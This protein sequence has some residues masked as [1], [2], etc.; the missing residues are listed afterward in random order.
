M[1]TSNISVKFENDSQI[2]LSGNGRAK[3]KLK[4]EWDDDPDNA[5]DAI[6][7]VQWNG[8]N[9]DSPGSDG[10]STSTSN[11]AIRG[12]YNLSYSGQP[13]GKR[14][15]DD[16]TICF[17]D[18]D[19]D[20]CNAYLTIEGSP[21]QQTYTDIAAALT[22]NSTAGDI[23][24]GEGDNVNVVWA[25]TGTSMNN[26]GE[27]SEGDYASAKERIPGGS[28]TEF[29]AKPSGS[30]T[31][32]NL[33]KGT[34]RYRLKTYQYIT[35]TEIEITRQVTVVEQ[36]EATLS[37]TPAGVIQN[38]TCGVGNT[39]NG[40]TLSWTASGFENGF[41]L[42]GDFGGAEAPTITGSDRSEGEVTFYPTTSGA[43]KTIKLKVTS[44]IET[45]PGVN[46]SYTTAAVSYDV[47]D[48]CPSA[49]EWDDS[50]D[51]TPL[52]NENRES[53]TITIDGFSPTDASDNSLPISS[54]TSGLQVSVNGG[55]WQD[56]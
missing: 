27:S 32:K 55:P 2:T 28:Y 33:S 4:L 5:G 48:H 52:N 21:I 42:I 24:V 56:V 39:A 35:D 1:P 53:N 18:N 15:V 49:F 43:N 31:F 41:E 7:D 34:Y 11:V 8:I 14:K 51:N 17:L 54:N 37:I 50:T 44:E 20:D 13:Y 12:T 38:G 29:S 40:V 3:I 22:V 45:S 23:V 19:G 46:L 30:K 25:V 26:K 36:P 47:Y 9:M 16:N 10:S 6:D